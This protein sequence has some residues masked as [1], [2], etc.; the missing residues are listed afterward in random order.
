MT[1][2]F[3]IHGNRCPKLLNKETCEHN[4]GRLDFAYMRAKTQFAAQHNITDIDNIANIR[5]ASF[6]ERISQL[7]EARN[8]NQNRNNR[9]E[10]SPEWTTRSK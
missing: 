9:G 1:R 6:E 8:N 4:H 3:C 2:D 10:K 7:T 5:I